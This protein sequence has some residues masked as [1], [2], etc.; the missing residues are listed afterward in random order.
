[1][2]LTGNLR[3]DHEQATAM[4]VDR[5]CG[6]YEEEQ[7]V[8]ELSASSLDCYKSAPFVNARFRVD[9]GRHRDA[10]FFDR[11]TTR[12]FTYKSVMTLTCCYFRIMKM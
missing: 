10:S 7:P 12:K 9:I 8:H 6:L 3:R 5:I 4:L 11:R 2:V 1:M